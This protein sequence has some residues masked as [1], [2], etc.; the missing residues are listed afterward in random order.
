MDGSATLPQL[1]LP[2]RDTGARVCVRVAGPR[3]LP[4]LLWN[5]TSLNGFT[6]AAEATPRASWQWQ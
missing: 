5:V 4:S 6:S 3:M 1:E 2:Y